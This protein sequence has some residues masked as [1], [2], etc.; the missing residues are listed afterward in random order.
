MK[1]YSKIFLLLTSFVL[2]LFISACSSYNYLMI[3][4]NKSKHEQTI[5]V[6]T[7]GV[8]SDDLD[9]IKAMSYD[10][11]WKKTFASNGEFPE[12]KKVFC[13]TP[14]NPNTQGIDYDDKIWKEWNSNDA[15]YLCIAAYS[16]D[17]PTSTPVI[18]KK[19]KKKG[20]HKKTDWRVF[21]S[22]SHRNWWGLSS[23]NLK[24]NIH[25]GELI[26]D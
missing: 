7:F 22:L 2:L 24:I 21:L 16:S 5:E 12:N 10:E 6:Y 3:L 14:D 11:F 23:E 20:K 1:S 19:D 4:S 17:S 8:S 15:E 25:D 13:F 26:V 18:S 9:D